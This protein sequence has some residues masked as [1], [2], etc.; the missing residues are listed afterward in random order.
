MRTSVKDNKL[1]DFFWN[2]LL[3]DIQLLH[4]VTGKSIDDVALL[5]H[6]VLQNIATTRGPR[7]TVL[8]LT[9]KL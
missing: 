5:I 1:A 8:A 3:R 6:L 4:E 7:G 9:S 2:H